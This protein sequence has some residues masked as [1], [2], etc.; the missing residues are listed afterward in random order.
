[1]DTVQSTKKTARNHENAME[2]KEQGDGVPDTVGL[3]LNALWLFPA[4]EPL[5]V[6]APREF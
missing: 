4:R 5:T 6:A 1:M 3:V 2:F